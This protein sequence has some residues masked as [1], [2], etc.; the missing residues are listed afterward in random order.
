MEIDTKK[1]ANNI[2]SVC[3]GLTIF[4]GVVALLVFVF[5]VSGI[6][7]PPHWSRWILL[8]VFICNA[9]YVLPWAVIVWLTREE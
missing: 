9:F 8:T 1:V 6:K 2:S 4:F 7:T 5:M 3:L